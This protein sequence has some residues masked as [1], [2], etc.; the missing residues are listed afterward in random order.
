MTKNDQKITK[1]PKIPKITKNRE[2]KFENSEKCQ[3]STFVKNVGLFRPRKF[4]AGPFCK[5]FF[6]MPLFGESRQTKKMNIRIRRSE[7]GRSAN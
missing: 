5:I 4:E 2:K 6:E 3:K 1:N 7:Q